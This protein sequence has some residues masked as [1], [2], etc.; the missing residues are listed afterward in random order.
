MS[1]A[2]TFNPVK[3]IEE[4]KARPGLYDPAH[5][6]DR[7]ERLDLWKEVGSVLFSDWNTYSKA[8]AYDRSK[9]S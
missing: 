8:T 3:F 5:P 2:L 6:M 7:N 1:E 9:Y 4:V